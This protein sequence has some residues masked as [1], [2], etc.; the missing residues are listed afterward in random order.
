MMELFNLVDPTLTIKTGVHT[1]EGIIKYLADDIE[2][3]E[4]AKIQGKK[5]HHVKKGGVRDRRFLNLE[6]EFTRTLHTSSRLGSVIKEVMRELWDEGAT[7][8]TTSSEDLVVTGATYAV[9][10]HI[11]PSDLEAEL[12]KTDLKNGFANRFIFTYSERTHM[13][14]DPPAISDDILHQYAT[15]LQM[16]LDESQNEYDEIIQRSPDA[17]DLMG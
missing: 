11:T 12:P 3:P 14:P 9:I 13:V 5:Y 4:I 1:G 2:L 15:Y 6:P 17:K 10:G 8:K 16:A 7:G